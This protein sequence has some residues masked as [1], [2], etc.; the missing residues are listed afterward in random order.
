V[1]VAKLKLELDD[2]LDKKETGVNSYEMDNFTLNVPET[3]FLLNKYFL[4]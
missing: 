1:V 4:S 3:L 2:L